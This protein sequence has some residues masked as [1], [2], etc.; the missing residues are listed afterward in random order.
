MTESATVTIK[1][2]GVEVAI[3]K[4]LVRTGLFKSEAEAIKAAMV[5]YAVDSQLLS[6]KQLWR[7]AITHKRRNVNPQA[8][9]DEL[10]RLEES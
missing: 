2:Q 7:K 8:L 3:L 6:K 4:E 9:S 1:L 10:R 5:K